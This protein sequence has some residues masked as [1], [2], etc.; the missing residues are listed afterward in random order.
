MSLKNRWHA[1]CAQTIGTDLFWRI[2]VDHLSIETEL[3]PLIDRYA[4]GVILDAGAGRLAWRSLLRPHS[5]AYIATDYATAHPELS[6]CADLQGRLPLRNACVD[7]IFCCSVMEHTPEPWL[8]LP[9]FARVLRPG[10][11]VIL[12]VPFLYFLHGAPHDYF[13]FTLYGAM[14]LARE[15]GLRIVERR[16]AGGLAHTVLQSVSIVLVA[17]LWT[18]RAPWL[19]TVPTRALL[20]TARAIDSIDYS[21]TFAQ[22]VNLVLEKSS[23][24]RASNDGAHI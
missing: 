17:I 23:I 8:I 2:A 20:A 19:V 14:R 3:R 1:A 12:S 24:A 21:G 10:G 5:T 22:T 11:R 9:E 15:A 16:T 18:P 13:R 7:T 6:F 4:R